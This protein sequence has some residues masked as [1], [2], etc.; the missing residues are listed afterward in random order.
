MAPTVVNIRH[1][2]RD[3]DGTAI[4]PPNSAYCGRRNRRYGVEQSPYHNPFKITEY[5]SRSQVIDLHL[6]A[7]CRGEL[8]VTIA[9]VKRELTDKDYL[10]CWCTPEPCHCDN[11]VKVINEDLLPVTA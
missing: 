3:W 4:L 9:D 5:V 6:I 1:L 11:Y 8:D 2:P 10:V 7:L